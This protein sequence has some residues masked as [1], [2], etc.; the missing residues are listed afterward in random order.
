[1]G[2]IEYV[3][4]ERLHKARKDLQE[5]ILTVEQIMLK[6]RFTHR[7]FQMYSN[8]FG[9]LPNATTT[10]GYIERGKVLGLCNQPL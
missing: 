2:P 5:G 6:F 7:F 9:E 8:K 1:M 4:S 3:N 10:L